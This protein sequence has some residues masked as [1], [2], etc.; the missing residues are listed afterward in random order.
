MHFKSA[1]IVCALYLLTSAWSIGLNSTQL[2]EIINLYESHKMSASPITSQNITKLLK[3]SFGIQ[4][5]EE[6][7]DCDSNGVYYVD[8]KELLLTLAYE[9]K[10]KHDS[11]E[12]KMLTSFEVEFF[13][14]LFIEHVNITDQNGY[15]GP[16]QLPSVLKDLK[17]NNTEIENIIE[18]LKDK[19]KTVQFVINE[20]DFLLT[21]LETKPE[22]YG[23][24]RQQIEKFIDLFNNCPKTVYG[25]IDPLEIQKIFIEFGMADPKHDSKFLFKS[26]RS[27]A[28]EI[29][30]LMLVTAERSRTIHTEH[31]ARGVLDTD[32][33]QMFLSNFVKFDVDSDGILSHEEFVSW[34]QLARREMFDE[35]KCGHPRNN[36]RSVTNFAKFLKMMLP[37]YELDEESYFY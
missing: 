30:E 1:V 10:K 14:S 9:D 20:A 3:E 17:L 31:T 21:M 5:P 19:K 29:M 16:E 23:L 37:Y 25:G 33:V 36:D 4:K 35:P 26:S 2:S 18:K 27:A 15:S 32:I 6:L 28:K 13:L 34:V 7:F 12:T 11:F 22:G 24:V 8:L